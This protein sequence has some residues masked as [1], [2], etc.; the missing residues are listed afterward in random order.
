[1]KGKYVFNIFIIIILLLNAYMLLMT[2][3]EL[4]TYGDVTNPTNNIVKDRYIQEGAFE[5]GGHNL[6]ANI[7]VG[8]RGYDTLIEVTVLF[9]AILA[10]L[11]TLKSKQ[12]L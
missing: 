1:M 9:A 10:I 7:I 3:V 2:V 8:Y 5:V 6:V 12:E 4:P 11:I